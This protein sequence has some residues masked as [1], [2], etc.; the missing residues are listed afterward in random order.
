MSARARSGEDRDMSDDKDPAN[1]TAEPAMPAGELD[2]LRKLAAEYLTL[3]SNGL[4][5]I[6]G[7]Q[8]YL[9]S[10]MNNERY[11]MTGRSSGQAITVEPP[12]GITEEMLKP[13]LT[14]PEP[15]TAALAGYLMC[16]L[17]KREGLKPLLRYWQEHS[18][19]EDDWQRLVYRAISVTGTDT[20]LPGNAASSKE[21]TERVPERSARNGFLY[22]CAAGSGTDPSR[23]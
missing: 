11:E 17:G 5:Y 18:R 15:R 22:S 19:V 4:T 9:Q 23:V 16:T 3:N 14:D 12:K 2:K 13:L 21:R 7:G 1:A 8:L 6:R 20:V 10:N